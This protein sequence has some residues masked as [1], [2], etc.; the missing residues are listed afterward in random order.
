MKSTDKG[1]TW[2][3]ISSNIPDGILVW[4]IVQDHVKPELIFAAT[5]FEIYFTIN[6][7]G[8][9]IKLKGNVPTISF[10]DLAIQKHENDLVGASFGRGFFVFDDYSVLK[11]I[12]EQQ[13]KQEATLFSTRKAWWYVPR[14]Y[15]SFDNQKGSQWASHY[16]APNPPFGAVFT[17]YLKVRT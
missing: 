5:E 1:K 17:Y 8:R 7:G 12:S 6:G 9:W 14:S 16:V 15:L 4:R 3:S 2:Q 11:E 10:R 13:L